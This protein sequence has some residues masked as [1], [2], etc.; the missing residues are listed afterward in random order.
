MSDFCPKCGY[1]FN[2]R[3]NN[4]NRYCWGVVVK[5]ISDET[6]N[7]ANDVYEFLKLKFNQKSVTIKGQEHVIGGSLAALSKPEFEIAME[8]VRAWALMEYGIVIPL[9][10][11]PPEPEEIP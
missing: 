4:Q 10:N 6:G 3:S 2:Q 8:R 1:V 7:D 11:E 9:P 5:I